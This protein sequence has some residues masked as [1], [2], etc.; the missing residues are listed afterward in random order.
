MISMGKYTENK[1]KII[2]ST[3]FWTK[4]KTKSNSVKKFKLWNKK[5]S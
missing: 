1:K 5:S 4:Y 2:L 3:P